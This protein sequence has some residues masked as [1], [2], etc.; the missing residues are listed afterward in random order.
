MRLILHIGT[1]KTGTTTIQKFLYTNRSMLSRHRIV[2]S[3]FLDNPNNRKLPVYC[4]PDGVIDDYL[5]L[6][7]IHTLKGK[8]AY[9]SGFPENLKTEIDTLSEHADTMIITSEHMHS[10]LTTKD[11]IE[12]LKALLDPLFSDIQIICYVREQSALLK[13]LYSTAMK[14][15]HTTD[16]DM[17]AKECTPKSLRYNYH[18]SLSRWADVF[19]QRAITVRLFDRSTFVDGDIRNDLLNTIQPELDISDFDFEGGEENASIGLFGLKLSQ[20]INTK[21][22]KFRKDG[23]I[24]VMRTRMVARLVRSR[25]AGLGELTVQDADKIHEDFAPSNAAMASMFLDRNDNPFALRAQP[26]NK[27]LPDNIPIEDVQDLLQNTV[28]GLRGLAVLNLQDAKALDAIA[29]RLE[30]GAKS[31]SGEIDAL[32]RIANL[33]IPKKQIPD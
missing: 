15:G 4:Q 18:L 7:N 32:R 5:R 17:F 12:R 26:D 10:R 21:L 24:N 2:L 16:F 30:N 31:T 13:S 14:V 28:T 33:A 3:D 27:A 22:P 29:Q 11:S 8:K 9:L 6:R 23:S 25:V 1:E 19:G 20:M